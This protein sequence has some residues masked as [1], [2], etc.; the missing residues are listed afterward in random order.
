MLNQVVGVALRG[1]PSVEMRTGVATEGH[2]LQLL[3]VFNAR[4]QHIVHRT[5]RHTLRR[6]RQLEIFD[7]DRRIPDHSR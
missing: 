4:R 3:A 7:L 1:H 5:S 2:P 6:R